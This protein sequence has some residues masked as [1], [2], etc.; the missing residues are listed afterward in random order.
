MTPLNQTIDESL[1]L[2][3]FEHEGGSLISLRV[4]ADNLDGRIPSQKTLQA[5]PELG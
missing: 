4:S 3:A 2:F 1:P 5:L